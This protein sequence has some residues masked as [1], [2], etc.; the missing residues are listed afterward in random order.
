MPERFQVERDENHLEV[1]WRWFSVVHI[2][3]V[4]FCVVWDSFLIF[5]YSAVISVEGAAWIM[6]VFPL[7][8]VAVGLGLTYF[9]IA[10]FLNRTRLCASHEQLSVA[11]GPLPW[12]GA[13]VL[14]AASIGQLYSRELVTQTRSGTQR[15]YELQAIE[16][17]GRQL[18]LLRGLGEVEQA[19]WLEQELERFLGLQDREVAGEVERG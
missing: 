2:F 18:R 11:H 1:S 16:K 12:F 4:F 6:A 17:S 15:S 5:W 7:A 8:H 19:L 3:L 14:P 10:G 9:T 13:R